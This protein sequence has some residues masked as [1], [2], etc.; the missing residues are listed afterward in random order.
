[1]LSRVGRVKL[2]GEVKVLWFIFCLAVCFLR[3]AEDSENLVSLIST[4][5]AYVNLVGRGLID[6]T[7]DSLNLGPGAALN[8][9]KSLL[10]LA[11]DQLLDEEVPLTIL[12]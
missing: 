4:G 2:E 1:M 9:E 8:L 7:H 12:R 10:D 5:S 11:S 3:E 6:D